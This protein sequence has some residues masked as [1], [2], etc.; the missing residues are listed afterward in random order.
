[1]VL[2]GVQHEGG[3]AV[4]AAAQVPLGRREQQEGAAVR[5]RAP[6]AHPVPLR[7]QCADERAGFA[8]GD[9]EQQV[10]RCSP[11]AQYVGVPPQPVPPAGRTLR[12]GGP[13][14]GHATVPRPAL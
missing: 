10:P 5:R 12:P 8:G 6:S 7:W 3:Q 4:S 11:P 9:V 1:M 13:R 2:R 14:T